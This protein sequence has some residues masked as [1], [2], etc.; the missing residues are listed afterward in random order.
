MLFT[1]HVTVAGVRP[2]TVA[3]YC[4]VAFTPI[5][6]YP[7]LIFTVCPCSGAAANGTAASQFPIV[8]IFKKQPSN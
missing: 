8:L 7:G 1:F 4:S 2:V 3:V 5:D 6:V